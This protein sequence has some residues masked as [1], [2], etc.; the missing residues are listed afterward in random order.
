MQRRMLRGIKTRVET[1]AVPAPPQHVPPTTSVTPAPTV[2][3]LPGVYLCWIPLGAGA[4]VVRLS[5][6]TFEALSALLQRRPRRDLYHSALVAVTT[7][8]RYMIEMTPVVDGRGREDRGVVAEG[9]VGTRWARRFRVF[10]YEIRR[11]SDG[12]I[13]D[14]RYAVASPVRVGDGH[15]AHAVFD[16]VPVVPTPVWGRDE[17]HAGEMW[18]SNS[19]TSWLLARSGIDLEHIRPPG[20]GRA[21]GWDAGLA[22]AGLVKPEQAPARVTEKVGA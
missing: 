6:K 18:N 12:A 7:D 10:R 5:G 22:V 21:P 19:V 15:A 8:A 11:W 17:L 2:P 13:P 3:T 4:R 14:L 16:L 1:L 9:A 20:D